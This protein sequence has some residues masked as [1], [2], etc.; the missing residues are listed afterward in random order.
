MT[1]L[2]QELLRPASQYYSTPGGATEAAKVHAVKE[3]SYLSSMDQ[4]Y[5]EL[6]EM[7][8]QFDLRLDLEQDKFGLEER[9]FELTEER[10]EWEKET[11][12][13]DQEL[14]WY[15]ARTDRRQVT[16]NLSARQSELELAREIGEKE[17]EFGRD[18]FDW[19]QR[20]AGG[21][22]RGGVTTGNQ[23]RYVLPPG[24]GTKKG[25]GWDPGKEP[26]PGAGS[27]TQHDWSS[28]PEPFDY[29]GATPDPYRSR[30]YR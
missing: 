9:K 2:G 25:M 20:Q 10:F 30:S 12:E 19:R 18:E 27:G 8:R 16:G 23:S 7:E 24:F 29:G 26:E 28:A 6:A 1:Q 5:A 13:E 15:K 22:L 14:D 21:R 4:F 3:A 17:E 11:S